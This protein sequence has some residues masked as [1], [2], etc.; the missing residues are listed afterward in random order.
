MVGCVPRLDLPEQTDA[1][2]PESWRVV[3]T[4]GM[5]ADLVRHIVGPRGHVLGLMGE[6]VDPHLFKPTVDDVKQLA[7]ADVIVYNGFALEGRLEGTLEQLRRGGRRVFAVTDGLSAAERI[8][9]GHAG[10]HSDPHVWMDVGLWKRCARHVA[11]RFSELDPA[12]RDEYLAR[13]A[14]Y[15]A[16][17]EELDAYIRRI[18]ASIPERQRVLVTAHD[19]FHYFSRAYNI[20]VRSAQG[21]S[22]ESEPGVRDINL[23][24]DFLVE[25]RIRAIFVES[26]VSESNLRAILEGA[27]HRGWRVVIG[28][29]LYSDA[30]GPRGTHEGTYLGMMDHNATTIAVALGGDV[31]AGGWRGRLPFPPAPLAQRGQR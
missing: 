2:P 20:P 3:A 22:T 24:V 12:H 26:S 27:R 6:G 11:E 1:S 21:I 29:E 5:V 4:T 7:R 8:G 15:E 30:M 23:L 14:A 28:G 17:L 25:R 10:S 9:A 19:A 31:P 18:I 13:G 16:Q